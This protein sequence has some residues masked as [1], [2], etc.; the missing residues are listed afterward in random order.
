M[1][2]VLPSTKH[3]EW[4]IMIFHVPCYPDMTGFE[5]GPALGRQIKGTSDC[6][7]LH[8]EEGTKPVNSG[9]V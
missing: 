6:W 5:K 7:S 8:C 2:A 1:L 4:A 3:E 9:L